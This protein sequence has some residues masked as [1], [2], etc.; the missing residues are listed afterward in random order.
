[1]QTKVISEVLLAHRTRRVDLVAKNEERH[2]AELLDR[3]QRVKLGL[4]LA[5][6]LVVRA[7]DKENNP[8]HLREVVAP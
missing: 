7:V 6:S 8:V 2:L 3:Q 5:E 4:A 1:M